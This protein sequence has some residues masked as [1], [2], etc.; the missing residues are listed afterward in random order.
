MEYTPCLVSK[1]CIELMREFCTS[2]LHE[3]LVNA[4]IVA[5][6]STTT[7]SGAKSHSST[8][9]NGVTNQVVGGN[10]VNTLF[11]PIDSMKQ[12]LDHFNIYRNGMVQ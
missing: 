9:S 7:A 1:D 6:N 10:H 5:L 4:A 2:F 11:R 3:S 12:Y 8:S